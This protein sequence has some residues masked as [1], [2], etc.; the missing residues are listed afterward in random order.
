MK[1]HK[2][3]KTNGGVKTEEKKAQI[4]H[5]ITTLKSTAPQ[6]RGC[7]WFSVEWQTVQACQ[8]I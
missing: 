7:K 6:P 3:N 4:C 5:L 1:M 8:A 2:L